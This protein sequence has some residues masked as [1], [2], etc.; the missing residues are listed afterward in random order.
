MPHAQDA[1]FCISFQHCRKFSHCMCCA[2][3]S[4]AV[5]AVDISSAIPSSC[6]QSEHH[7]VM[8]TDFGK[9]KDV[10]KDGWTLGASREALLTL[11]VVLNLEKLAAQQSSVG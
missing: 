10:C 9:H 8:P 2:V 5:F 11:M 1:H 4:R 6:E 3:L 7:S